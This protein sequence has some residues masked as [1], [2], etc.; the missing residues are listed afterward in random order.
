MPVYFD[1]VHDVPQR[2]KPCQAA[3]IRCVDP[4]CFKMCGPLRKQPISRSG[5]LRKIATMV[6]AKKRD[7]L[8]SNAYIIARN[9]DYMTLV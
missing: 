6:I 5:W 4:S 3:E 7:P 1:D 9:K 2:F 8:N